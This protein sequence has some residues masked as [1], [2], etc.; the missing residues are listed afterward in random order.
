M[1]TDQ[2]QFDVRVG[3]VLGR[4]R[5]RAA[6]QGMSV[7]VSVSGLVEQDVDPAGEDFVAGL[8]DDMTATLAEF[9]ENFP[10]GLR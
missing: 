1:A 8:V 10:A 6:R 9:E 7:Q 5:E 3:D 4:V 2:Q